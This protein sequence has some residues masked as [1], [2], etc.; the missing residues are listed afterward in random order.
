MSQRENKFGQEFSKY[1]RARGGMVNST[2]ASSYGYP[3]WP[4][5]QVVHAWWQG[6]VELKAAHTR[7]DPKQARCLRDL[8]ARWPWHAVQ[9]RDLGDGMVRVTRYAADKQD[10][11]FDCRLAE[12]LEKLVFTSVRFHDKISP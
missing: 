5:K 10:E 8:D 4:D 11:E 7:T 3:G 2:V 1:W 12:L 9:V 6:L